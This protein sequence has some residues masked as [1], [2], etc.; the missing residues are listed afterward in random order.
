MKQVF[1][2]KDIQIFHFVNGK[3]VYG[4]PPGLRGNASDL[5]GDVS[6]LSGDVTGL[7]GDATGLRGDV[8]KC[9]I[10]DS[11]RAAGVDVALLTQQQDD[12]L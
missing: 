9:D 10:T 12:A 5:S 2:R 4:T 11:E 8:D 3:K 1:T 6:G 7:R